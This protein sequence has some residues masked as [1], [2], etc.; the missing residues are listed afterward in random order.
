MK[1][2]NRELVEKVK[3]ATNI[4]SLMA[5]RGIKLVRSG[6]KLKALC[7]F[8]KEKTPSFSVDPD[9]GLYHCFGCGA[10][11]DA[12]KFVMESDGLDF[13]EALRYLAERAGIEIA[14]PDLAA[15]R[16]RALDALDFAMK[17]YHERLFS[18]EGKAGLEYMQSRGT[19][20]ETLNGFGLGFAPGGNALMRAAHDAGFGVDQL[21]AAGLVSR[22]EGGSWFDFFRDRIV[23]PVYSASGRN[24]LGFSGRAIGD[25]EPKYLN[26]PE[27]PFFHKGEILYGLARARTEIRKKGEAML[28][29]GNV[30]V[31]LS[32]QAGFTNAVA[33]L[34]TALTPSHAKTLA[35]YAEKVVVAFDGD[36]AGLAAARRSIPHLLAEGLSVRVARLSEGQDPAALVTAGEKAELERALANAEGAVEFIHS[37]YG[38]DTGSQKAFVKEMLEALRGLSDSEFLDIYLR[39]MARLLGYS[40]DGVKTLRQHISLAETPS[41]PRAGKPPANGS[42]RQ[43]LLLAHAFVRSKEEPFA[44]GL[45]MLDPRDLSHPLARKLAESF[46]DGKGMDELVAEDR[47]TADRVSGIV[48]GDETPLPEIRASFAVFVLE[49][50]QKAL[51][52]Q[53]SEAEKS[54]DRS[55]RNAL[56]ARQDINRRMVELLRTLQENRRLRFPERKALLL[57]RLSEVESRLADVWENDEEMVNAYPGFRA[58]MEALI[59]MLGALNDPVAGELFNEETEGETIHG[60][61]KG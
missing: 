15:P 2:V 5:E 17:Y 16:P 27:T 21:A 48:L 43:V 50:R 28:V 3:E 51:A 11:G 8:H 58:E 25:A 44:S 34:G 55:A 26:T 54:P 36:S 61:G 49:M 10:S 39:R 46:R 53:M 57:S 47:E 52:R 20:P 32:H 45:S 60:K 4:A 1:N 42:G 37:F 41:A 31:V 35:R 9:L 33:P 24:V 30:D 19:A 7:P 38:D 22:S 40:E 12:I 13:G 56:M 14:G 29:E 18:P 6:H 59:R 23:F